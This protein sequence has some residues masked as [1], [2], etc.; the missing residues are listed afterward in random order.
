MYGLLGSPVRR[1]PQLLSPSGCDARDCAWQFLAREDVAERYL[2][3][4]RVYQT[5]RPGEL[6]ASIILE[7]IIQLMM[8]AVSGILLISPMGCE[9]EHAQSVV[10]ML[11]PDSEALQL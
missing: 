8:A 9:E 1:L 6:T 10:P 2:E 3:V 5:L 11:D 7:T 4:A